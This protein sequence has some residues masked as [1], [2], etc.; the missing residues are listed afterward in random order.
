MDSYQ[1]LLF[2]IARF[3]EFTGRFP[4]KITIVGYDFKRQRFTELHR[5]ALR[6]P[7]H[8]FEYVG[9]DPDHDG[10]T[11]AIDGEVRVVRLLSYLILT[12]LLETKWI[13]PLFLGL[14]WVPLYAAE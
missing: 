7:P 11:T 10:S 9:L 8:K 2:S 12:C 5:K 1:N 3:R 13:Y 14:V 6:W 4:H